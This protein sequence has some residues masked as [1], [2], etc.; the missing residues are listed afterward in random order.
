MFAQIAGNNTIVMKL[1]D[2]VANGNVKQRN[3]S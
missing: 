3:D 1:P 2:I